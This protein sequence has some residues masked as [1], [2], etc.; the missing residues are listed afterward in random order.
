MVVAPPH[1]HTQRDSLAT[2]PLLSSPFSP[3]LDHCS[4]SLGLLR[5]ALCLLDRPCHTMF[6]FL[7]PGV[8]LA[9]K[10]HCPSRLSVHSHTS[11]A[12]LVLSVASR[13]FSLSFSGWHQK[14]SHCVAEEA[15]LPLCCCFWEFFT[16]SPLP[17]TGLLCRNNRE[18][19]S[20]PSG[21][22]AWD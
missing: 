15:P 14:Q 13:D 9:L 8:R 10:S 20:V 21:P 5:P 17:Y 12:T 18:C 19:M 22:L 6:T 1:T 3:G 4:P 11:L 2:P 7:N 16:S